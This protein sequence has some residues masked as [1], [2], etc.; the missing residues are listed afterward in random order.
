MGDVPMFYLAIS[1]YTHKLSFGDGL[2]FSLTVFIFKAVFQVS[3]SF[4]V[5]SS[6]LCLLLCDCY[7]QRNTHIRIFFDECYNHIVRKRLC[8]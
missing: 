4:S 6:W 7:L 3:L 8:G 2:P 5:T 1:L